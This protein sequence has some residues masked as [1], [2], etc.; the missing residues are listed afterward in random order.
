MVYRPTV[1]YAYHP[2]DDAVLSVHEL[3]GRNWIM[4]DRKRIIGSRDS[5]GPAGT[6]QCFELLLSRLR[7]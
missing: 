4:Q 1:H 5:Y 3:A 2:S 7:L 6:F